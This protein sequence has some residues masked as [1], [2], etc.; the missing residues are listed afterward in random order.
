MRKLCISKLVEDYIYHGQVQCNKLLD[1][2][3]EHTS[4]ITLHR[5]PKCEKQKEKWLNILGIENL[6]TKT[7]HIFICSLHFEE[8]CFNRTLNV[9]RLRDDALPSSEL[10]LPAQFE[11]CKEQESV[12]RK[13]LVEKPSYST[14]NY[15]ELNYAHFL[16]GC[17]AVLWVIKKS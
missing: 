12:S 17:C 3:Q 14:S 8:K 15:A 13:V 1:E 11:D 7:K 5:L 9:T 2:K 6:N 16:R 4:N 10:L